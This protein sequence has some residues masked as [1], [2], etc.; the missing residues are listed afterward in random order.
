[1]LAS[2]QHDDGE[3][4]NFTKRRFEA[5]K[6]IGGANASAMLAVAVFL[7]AGGRTGPAINSG[8]WCFGL[9]AMGF[10]AFMLGF[11]YLYRF[12]GDLEDALILVRAEV[13]AT[14]ASVTKMLGDAFVR[15]ERGGIFV[16]V[17][18]A[19]FVIGGLWACVALLAS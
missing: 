1:M 12:E 10:A 5:L 17:S 8:K 16:I 15:S 4:R 3:F 9:F 19:C 13:K 2:W 7:T 11:R 18:L 6:M 14:D